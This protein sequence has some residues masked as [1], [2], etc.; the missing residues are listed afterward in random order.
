[1]GSARRPVGKYSSAARDISDTVN[2]LPRT[3]SYLIDS[4][5]FALGAILFTLAVGVVV[6]GGALLIRATLQ[7]ARPITGSQG[8]SSLL[9]LLVFAA[10]VGVPTYLLAT[11]G[12][13]V[14]GVDDR[15]GEKL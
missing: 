13:A 12:E 1:M 11:R 3:G 9:A 14:L 15:D 7:V 6:L 4:M 2:P 8:A 5:L 10:Y